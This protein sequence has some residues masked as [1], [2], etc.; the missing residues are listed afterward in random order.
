MFNEETLAAMGT[1]LAGQGIRKDITLLVRRP[2]PITLTTAPT[3]TRTGYAQ[4]HTK[5]QDTVTI[6]RA[7][8]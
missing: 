8:P 5:P 3:H 7:P 6:P 2:N 4:C 1:K